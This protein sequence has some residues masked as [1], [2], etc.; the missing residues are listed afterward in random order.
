[1]DEQRITK[2]EFI[3]RWQ[4]RQAA[5]RKEKERMMGDIIRRHKRGYIKYKIKRDHNK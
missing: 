1:M 2:E 3:K 5:K 4:L